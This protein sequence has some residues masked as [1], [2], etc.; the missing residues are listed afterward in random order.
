M[1]TTRVSISLGLG[2]SRSRPTLTILA[3]L[4]LALGTTLL[5]V[6][7]GMVFLL[8]SLRTQFASVLTVELELIQDAD[9]TRSEVMSRAEAWPS[10]ESVQYVPP[11][12]T[13]REIEKETGE[14]LQKLFG[15]NPFPPMIRVR[16]GNLSLETL[17]SL[18][19]AARQWPQVADVAYP[20]A[21]WSSV[22]KLSARLQGSFGT[23]AAGIALAILILVG[24]CL[25]A[26]V[27]NRADTWDFLLLIGSSPR[28]IRMALFVQQLAVGLLGGLLTCALLTGLALFVRWLSLRPVGVP[29]WFY[30]CAVLLA[31]LLS[32]LAGQLSPRRFGAR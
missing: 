13:L 14:D 12:V 17:D 2:T 11:E 6:L 4:L 22:D 27:R 23:G 10:V 32:I 28:T 31:I 30:V 25:R 1:S 19:G 16:F 29:L 15:T 21:T 24:L 7:F 26:Q 9:S 3:A 5:C 8:Q 20:R 18:A